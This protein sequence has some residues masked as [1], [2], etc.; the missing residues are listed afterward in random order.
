MY[1]KY[2]TLAKSDAYWM[3]ILFPW[4]LT[5]LLLD[6]QRP[7]PVPKPLMIVGDASYAIYLLHPTLLQIL[8]SGT[9]GKSFITLLAIILVGI[10][11]YQFFERPIRKTLTEAIIRPS[12]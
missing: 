8:P 6:K 11:V 3:P 10:A 12:V 4:V 5:L 9:H 2:L 7:I 1:A